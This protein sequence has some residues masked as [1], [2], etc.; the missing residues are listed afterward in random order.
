MLLGE[1]HHDEK[2]AAGYSEDEITRKALQLEGALVPVTAAW[3][4][5]LLRSAG[6][7]DVDCFWRSLNFAAWVAVRS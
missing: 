7:R 4:V 5:D 6:F 1:L 2:R 3:N